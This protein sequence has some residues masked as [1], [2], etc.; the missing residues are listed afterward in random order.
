MNIEAIK[1][2]LNEMESVSGDMYDGSLT[3]HE[4]AFHDYARRIREALEEEP[5]RGAGR[6]PP[7]EALREVRDRLSYFCART[8]GKYDPPWAEE[9]VGI[10]DE[11]ETDSHAIGNAAA[12]REALYE[13]HNRVNSLDE[14]CGVDPI[15]VRDIARAA[16][17]KPPRNCDGYD[18]YG[19]AI[20]AFEDAEDAEDYEEMAEWL[21]APATEQEGGAK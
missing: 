15:E 5:R 9:L 10:I 6:I 19:D 1:S 11:A 8:D 21:F 17:A 16:L 13:I 3:M 2:V 7:K 18:S 4:N 14:E 20:R 12:M